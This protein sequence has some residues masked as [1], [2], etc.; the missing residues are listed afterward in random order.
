MRKVA[1]VTNTIPVYRYPI[2]KL[3]CG[4]A[5]L[6]VRI[7]VTV[8]LSE[9]CPEA[10][11]SL[12]MHY[13]ASWNA[14][15][16]TKHRLSGAYQRE[17]LPIPLKL[18]YDL[19]WFRPDVIVSGDLGLRSLVCWC[20]ARFMKAKFVL[21]SEEIISS[22]LGRSKLQQR[23]RKC[24]IERADGF[25]A[26]GEPARRYLL[27][28]NVQPENIFSCAQAI[29]NEFWWRHAQLIDRETERGRLGLKGTVFL[30]VGRAVQS[31][32]FQNFLEAW[33]RL[34]LGLHA[35]ISAVIAGDGDY[36]PEL[37]GFALSHRL[38]NVN[39]VGAKPAPELAR[40]YAA[41]DIFVVPSLVDVWGLVI[42]EAI[43]FGLPVLASRYA[44]ASQSLITNS[45]RG[46]VFDP[47]DIDEFEMRLR[48]WGES[49]PSRVPETGRLALRDITFAKSSIAIQEMIA[50]IDPLRGHSEG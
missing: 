6:D 8:P 18:V 47:A 34:P 14:I 23:L 31:K 45:N 22:A 17:L 42:N 39:F 25:L 50:K 24:L 9:S 20:A 32:G 38:N 43:C 5:D 7:L 37:K 27:G 10:V 16:T 30:L 4:V 46:I 2:F 3:V 41:A 1:F 13:S 12:P 11:A 28:F 35:R 33:S 44:G 36:L 29:D 40:L 19:L 48:L 49:P 15:R 21:S 26:W